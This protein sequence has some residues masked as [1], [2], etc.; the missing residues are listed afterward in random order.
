MEIQWLG[1]ACFKI[2]HEGY[3]VVI[4][5]YNAGYVN[6]YPELR[7]KA[8]KVLV[9]HEHYGHNYRE[10]V[11]LSGRP[12]SDC[13]FRISTMEVYH[14][15]VFG[16]LHGTCL[17]HILEADGLKAVHTGDLGVHLDESE[18]AQIFGADALMICAGSYRALPA[19]EVWRLT[20]E[21]FPKAI[22]PMH[23]HDG[24][25]GYK[26]LE[27]LDDLI[28]YYDADEMIHRYDT[29][30]ITIDEDTEPQIAV[31]KYLGGNNGDFTQE[32]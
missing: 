12:E 19:Q 3:S 26:R 13:P 14:D 29:D 25:R 7:V 6:G 1:H 2:T 23:Y 22:I 11:I 15:A 18:Q 20:D 28:K 16:R 30:R 4:D 10:G 5:P 32:R 9:S 27:T 8:D 31:L 24:K 21:V 17:V